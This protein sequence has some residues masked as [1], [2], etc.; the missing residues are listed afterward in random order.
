MYYPYVVVGA[1]ITGIV[2]AERLSLLTGFSVLLIEKRDHVGG[3]LHDEYNEHGI[4]V[5]QYG[6]HIVHTNDESVWSYLSQF[7]EWYPVQIKVKAMI[8]GVYAS[9]PINIKTMKELYNKDFTPE[10]MRNYFDG[11]SIHSAGECESAEDYLISR[12]GVDLYSK[13]YRDYIKKQWDTETKNIDISIVK[14]LPIRFS[15]DDRYFHDRFQ[16]VPKLGYHRMFKKMLI[17]KNI[18]LMLNTPFNEIA[19]KIKFNHLFFTGPIDEFFEYRFGKLQ[20]RGIKFIS[21]TLSC[22][23][24]QPCPITVYPSLYEYT[25]VTEYKQITGQRHHLTTLVKEY[26]TWNDGDYYPVLTKENMRRAELYKNEKLPK[27]ITLIGRL[28]EYRYY[29]IDDA[30]GRALSVVSEFLAND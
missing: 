21:E 7:T 13:I 16:G 17:H 26:P 10:Q 14:R 28:A 4:L 25:R 27:N 15:N 23:K 3:N 24:S 5:H 12:V 22:E 18:S 30:V 6:P 1:G 19:K 20:F 29:N 9:I 2:I 11:F 8:N